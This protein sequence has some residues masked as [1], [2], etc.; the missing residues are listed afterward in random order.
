MKYL[1]IDYGKKKIG[2]ALSEGELASAWRVIEV[3][4]LKDILTKMIQIIKAEKVEVVIVGKPESGEAKNLVVKF[5]D[6][7]KK[8]FPQIPIAQVEETLSTNQAKE[9]MLKL[10]FSQKARAK[11][12][13]FA[14]AAILQDYLDR[15]RYA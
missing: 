8:R 12:D 1:G 10:N 3:S 15:K 14:A 2:L 5:I 11:E 6:E 13:A 9:M 4:G 7:F